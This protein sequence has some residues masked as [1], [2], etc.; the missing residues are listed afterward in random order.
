MTGR[1]QVEPELVRPVEEGS[2]LDVLV[3]AHARVRRAPRAMLGVEVGQDGAVEDRAH[4]DD[5]ELEP[6]HVGDGGRVRLG[7]R[8][9]TPVVDSVEMDELHVRT[10]H[11]ISVPVQ[12]RR[13]DGGIDAAAH[14]DEDRGLSGH[15]E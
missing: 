13:G 15:R 4:V 9:A 7:L 1:H 10:P 5:L 6:D 2:E 8:A 12:D 14:G 3:A 11:A